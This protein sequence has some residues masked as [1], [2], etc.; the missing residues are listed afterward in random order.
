[1]ELI[2]RREPQGI[3]CQH[4][5]EYLD[6]LKIY[7]NNGIFDEQQMKMLYL[8]MADL[9]IETMVKSLPTVTRKELL[10]TLEEAEMAR[11]CLEIVENEVLKFGKYS[12]V[13]H[14]H[15]FDKKNNTLYIFFV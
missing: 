3:S 8:L 12:K 15:K 11:R 9:G 6:K 10:E 5:Q 2:P 4:Y 7:E 1:M 13:E 14:E